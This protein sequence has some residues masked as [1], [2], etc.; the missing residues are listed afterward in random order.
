M[1]LQY[2]YIPTEAL[3]G[4]AQ[5]GNSAPFAPRLSGLESAWCSTHVGCQIGR[6]V[7]IRGGA[8]Y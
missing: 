8:D 5:L 3:I 1:R 6:Q 4:D 2:I 7:R